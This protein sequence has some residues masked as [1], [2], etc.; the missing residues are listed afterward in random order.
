MLRQ[1][2]RYV[3]VRGGNSSRSR[4]SSGSGSIS[5]C[6]CCFL[7]SIARLQLL[8]LVLQRLLLLLLLLLQQL[9]LQ[10]LLLLLRAERTVRLLDNRW[11]LCCM[12]IG[13]HIEILASTTT[14]RS[15]LASG[16]A[17]VPPIE[18]I[19]VGDDLRQTVGQAAIVTAVLIET[20]GPIA[21][22]VTAIGVVAMY[23]AI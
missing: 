7:C 17:I 11:R 8:L 21:A 1:R 5:N 15:G 18:D 23:V 6:C 13:I 20:D 4:S 3:A 2:W 14:T 9:Q 10:L 22:K 19:A 12:Q 16:L